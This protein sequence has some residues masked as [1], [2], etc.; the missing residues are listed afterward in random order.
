M[1][2]LLSACAAQPNR[3]TTVSSADTIGY[4][5]R[6][7][8]LVNTSADDFSD[9]K[10]RAHELSNA[11]REHAPKLKPGD[12]P[13]LIA[14]ILEQADAD[15]R[16]E[17]FAQARREDRAFRALWEDE[18]GAVA[19][20][21]VSALQKQQEEA[22]CQAFDARPTVQRA[23]R[24]GFDRQLEKRLQAES[25]SQRMLE[26]ERSR[27]TPA[28]WTA[29]QRLASEISLASYLVNI[30]LIENAV[31]LDHLSAERSLVAETLADHLELEH[32]R[33]AQATKGNERQYAAERVKQIEASRKRLDASTAKLDNE[34]HDSDA[35]LKLAR[36]EYTAAY[37]SS[38]NAVLVK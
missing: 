22:G 16:R 3:P 37:N 14:R 4:A 32:A 5:L 17:A 7:P 11:L 21:T 15:G 35:Q 8:E 30:A 36:D 29:V 6:Y 2:A 31:Q 18:R 28:T 13:A 34:L 10:L 19:G 24:D 9:R 1:L 26:Q 12:D 27:L 38:R 20:R 23:L 25:E 33:E